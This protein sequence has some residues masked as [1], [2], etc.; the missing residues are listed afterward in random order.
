MAGVLAAYRRNTHPE[1]TVFQLGRIPFNPVFGREQELER[2]CSVWQ[3]NSTHLLT[4]QGESCV[5][6]S[7]LIRLWLQQ[8]ASEYW[9]DVDALFVWCFPQTDTPVAQRVAIDD[10][11]AHTL[12]W[13]LGENEN[14][15]PA[16]KHPQQIIER[17]QQQRVLLVLDNAPCLH[18]NGKPEMDA[19]L[20]VF[21]QQLAVKQQGM[22]LLA[23]CS[24]M[25]DSI[26]ESPNTE[27]M[28]L[29]MLDTDAAIQLLWRLGVQGDRKSLQRLVQQ[30]GDHP[31][32][33]VLTA[34][35]LLYWHEGIVQRADSIPI[36]YDP[37]KK[38][39]SIRRVLAAYETW[40]ADAPELAMLYFLPLFRQPFRVEDL[41][42]WVASFK[43]P[44]LA[45]WKSEKGSFEEMVSRLQFLSPENWQ[46][47]WQHLLDFGLLVPYADGE[48]TEMQGVV[49]EYFTHQLQLH[50]PGLQKGVSAVLAN[51]LTQP[52]AITG[53]PS[54]E[55][56][57]V[58]LMR[59]AQYHDWLGASEISS[60]LGEQQRTRQN[61]NEAIK[62]ARQA[63]VY[64]DLGMDLENLQNRLLELANL[65]E[66]SGA[67]AEAESLC[68]QAN[69]IQS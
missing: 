59:R 61:I 8:L 30:F 19:A 9:R 36:W 6:K 55:Q 69:Y 54:G 33:L 58:V 3:E 43:L 5:G 38:G 12:Q 67:H 10:F 48:Y 41:Q 1:Q 40:L 14:L 24:V 39:R 66:C 60:L 53:Q 13:L 18:I 7:S 44:W 2:L 31:A 45:R 20:L 50:Y 27:H 63:V 47:A 42:A 22:C 62:H 57:A 25:P 17:L 34:K 29:G 51:S 68:E 37:Q 49:G 65:L 11:F 35:Y 46:Q 52:E 28:E 21:L 16:Y 32:T 23:G 4:L 26:L 15:P 56:L 64:A